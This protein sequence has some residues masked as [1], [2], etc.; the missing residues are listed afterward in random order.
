MPVV[1]GLVLRA[2]GLINDHSLHTFLLDVGHHVKHLGASGGAGGA[3]GGAGSPTPPKDPDD[4]CAGEARAL[5]TAQSIAETL[6]DEITAVQKQ[7]GKLASPMQQALNQ[8][9]ALA[10]AAASEVKQQ[11]LMTMITKFLTTFGGE[12]AEAAN[13][14]YTLATN[15]LSSATNE[16]SE[17]ISLLNEMYQYFQVSQGNLDALKELCEENPMPDAQNFLNAM[18]DLQGL[19]AQ[20]YALVNDLNAPDHGLLDQLTKAQDTVDK[21]QKDLDDCQ[22]SHSGNGSSGGDTSGGGDGGSDA[23]V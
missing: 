9:A 7:I 5:K 10:P 15:P 21:D 3:A 4:P 20:G 13:A 1:I 17:N 16:L 6:Q 14:L 2:L 18:N 8:A 23:D 19:V 11:L 22:S 12:G